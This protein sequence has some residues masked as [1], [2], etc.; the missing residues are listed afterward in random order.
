M[1]QFFIDSRVLSG[2]SPR[3][4]LVEVTRLL[5]ERKAQLHEESIWI[6]GLCLSAIPNLQAPCVNG[7][8]QGRY[9]NA[10]NHN[11]EM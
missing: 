10:L 9:K 2:T 11:G 3:I 7:Q 8:C 1:R 6:C 5:D 4:D